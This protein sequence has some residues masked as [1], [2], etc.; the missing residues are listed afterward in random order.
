M[1]TEKY[2]YQS[3][4]RLD[5]DK[6]RSYAT[7]MGDNVPSVTTIIGKTKPEES[8]LALKN[9][10]KRIGDRQADLIVTEASARGTRMHKYLE[11]FILTDE[12]KPAGSNPYSQQSREMAKK[13]IENGLVNMDEVW[14]MEVPLYY[15]KV[16]AGT[17]DCIGKYKGK[18]AIID[19]K[20]TNRPKKKE[21]I[22]DYLIQLAAYGQAHDAVYESK[23][24]TGV[25]LMCSADYEFQHWVIEGDE[26][27]ENIT[28]WW[29]RVEEYYN[30]HH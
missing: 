28:K 3:L 1:I 27:K 23:I 5:S 18:P 8:K 21:W 22:E 11:D 16:Y 24:E 6:G 13:I 26:F 29:R 15:P 7:P 12:L 14:G 25:V 2:E 30:I 10:R 19:F 9:W 20:Q 4:T 17:T